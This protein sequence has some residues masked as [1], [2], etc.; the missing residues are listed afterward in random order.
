[1]SKAV[2]VR[3][4]TST[5][6]LTAMPITEP[7]KKFR[8][9][10]QKTW[11]KKEG[12]R[13]FVY[14]YIKNMIIYFMKIIHYWWFSFFQFSK[15]FKIKHINKHKPNSNIQ[16]IYT[17]A[18]QSVQDCAPCSLYCPLA[19]AVTVWVSGQYEPAGHIVHEPAFAAL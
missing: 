3:K 1:L 2:I 7:L 9:F 5:K 14:L 4:L 12:K 15:R 10:S 6:R 11:A 17:P 8:F 19:Q 18:G 16:N 13:I